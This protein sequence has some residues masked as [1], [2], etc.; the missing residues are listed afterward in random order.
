MWWISISRRSVPAV[1]C[2]VMSLMFSRDGLAQSRDANTNVALGS[3]AE[4][5]REMDPTKAIQVRSFNDGE[6]ATSWK[7]LSGGKPLMLILWLKQETLVESVE[8][9]WAKEPVGN[10]G[11]YVGKDD[12]LEDGRKIWD[13]PP[14]SAT[15]DSIVLDPVLTQC[16]YVMME[17][18]V[19][20]EEVDLKEF[21]VLGRLLKSPK[22]KPTRGGKVLS[23]FEDFGSLGVKLKVGKLSDAQVSLSDISA[24]GRFAMRV[25]CNQQ[26]FMAL[27]LPVKVRTWASFRALSFWL[28]GLNSGLS[29]HAEFTDSR[30][31]VFGGPT[32]KD[33]QYGWRRI[34][35]PLTL[36][37]PLDERQL[38]PTANVVTD[39][40]VWPLKEFRPLVADRGRGWVIFDLMEVIP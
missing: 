27:I 2:M 23:R 21:R 24:E 32:V 28:Y 7:G 26:D 34:E 9:R 4:V 33:D 3:R 29:F 5:W 40:I 22:A 14:G 8:L 39:R 11:V 13:R 38:Q 1:T 35:M 18:D 19:A 31:M 12:E 30:G 20:S 6:M 25:N 10:Y 37:F 15:P 16:V 36:F 17:A